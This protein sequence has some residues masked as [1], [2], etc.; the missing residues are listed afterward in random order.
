MEEFKDFNPYILAYIGWGPHNVLGYLRT[1]NIQKKIKEEKGVAIYRLMEDHHARV[2]GV[3]HY[4]DWN[5][6]SAPIY[7]FKNDKVTFEGMYADSF[8][9]HL[10]LFKSGLRNIIVQKANMSEFVYSQDCRLKVVN[11]LKEIKRLYLEAFPK[12]NFFVQTLPVYLTDD[13]NYKRHQKTL[14]LLKDNGIS[15]IDPTNFFLREMQKMG[16]N[17]FYYTTETGHLNSKYYQLM[18]K[19]YETYL[20]DTFNQIIDQDKELHHTNTK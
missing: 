10:Y 5:S 7:S 8:K 9:Y 15:I 1:N 4:F 18:M 6:G 12:G 14:D 2:C 20:S 17:D 19:Y 16:K 3:D 11:H 13:D